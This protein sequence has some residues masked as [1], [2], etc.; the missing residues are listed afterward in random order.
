MKSKLI[1]EETTTY[2]D[3]AAIP[4]QLACQF[5]H[6][7]NFQKAV[8]FMN[9][10]IA[11]LPLI[12]VLLDKAFNS[13]NQAASVNLM[14]ELRK[15]GFKGVFQLVYP[16]SV[17][18]TVN[19]VFS[20]H[21]PE[22]DSYFH[23]PSNT[24]FTT[25]NE[26][27]R[28]RTQG[29][30][31]PCK[32]GITGALDSLDIEGLSLATRLDLYELKGAPLNSHAVFLNTEVFVW[33]SP[34]YRDAAA[35]TRLELLE[36]CTLIKLS[37]TNNQALITPVTNLMET[38]LFLKNDK[39][40]HE[41]L[42]QKPAL[43]HFIKELKRGKK[44]ILPIYGW[45]TRDYPQNLFNIISGARYAQQHGKKT[46]LN[47]PLIIVCYYDIAI[48]KKHS[49]E[50]YLNGQFDFLLNQFNQAELSDV[51]H[52]IALIRAHINQLNLP[53]TVQIAS[54]S[55][56]HVIKS[57]D[58]LKPGQILLLSTGL[59]P[60]NV[61]DGLYTYH[62]SHILAPVREGAS[63]LSSLLPTTGK[64]HIYCAG[65]RTWEM[66]FSLA[67]PVL[68]ERLEKMG[69]HTCSMDTKKW[70][71]SWGQI[72]LPEMI[73]WYLIDAADQDSELA[74][75]FIKQRVLALK[76]ENNR[77]QVS[78]LVAEYLTR[79][80]YQARLNFLI[81]YSYNITNKIY[82]NPLNKKY[83]ER[84]VV[85]KP[86]NI[87]EAPICKDAE[88]ELPISN[89]LLTGVGK[90]VEYL[91]A[92]DVCAVFAYYE[93]NTLKQQ[94]YE[95]QVAANA[96]KVNAE[97][98][99]EKSMGDRILDCILRYCHSV[100]EECPSYF[101]PLS[102]PHKKLNEGLGTSRFTFFKPN[103]PLEMSFPYEH[104]PKT[105]EP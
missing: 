74:Q 91:D 70:L 84:T 56:P 82:Y 85:S 101:S 61:F 73:G 8:V 99:V 42:T 37:L 87:L 71:A 12:R 55:D 23:S 64:A 67:N 58:Q 7:N 43:L 88:Y 77:I 5:Y 97:L 94:L 52:T 31:E 83:E 41:L 76:P 49:L 46:L 33:F 21:L 80:S 28:R 30:I 50:N 40:G 1:I 22:Q 17:K 4:N 100:V 25:V 19:R 63:T 66:D 65:Q 34:Y 57:M 78:L 39:A 68:K 20:L 36:H 32:L 93:D 92:D 27:A 48:E 51:Q 9:E 35:D 16:A 14:K 86:T 54:L 95:P 102:S 26:F 105:L 45:T 90:E 13:G 44:N 24:E 18:N 3:I 60:K 11:S 103:P 6:T 81:P 59:L 96:A 62:A 75:V 79:L 2:Y 38:E 69:R 15:Q 10:H 29:L 104:M 98:I 89:E 53:N 72:N 47:R